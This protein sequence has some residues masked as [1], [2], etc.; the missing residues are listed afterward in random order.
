MSDPLKTVILVIGVALFAGGP[1]R[2]DIPAQ[3]T[4]PE[5]LGVLSVIDQNQI[6]AAQLA[7]QKNVDRTVLDFA[8]TLDVDHNTHLDQTKHL[9]QELKE[10]VTDTAILEKLRTEGRQDRAAL[11]ALDGEDFAQLYVADMIKGDSEA[12]NWMDTQKGQDTQVQDFLQETQ[13]E[14][15][16]HLKDAQKIQESQTAGQL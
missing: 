16:L 3:N 15:Y 1:V 12:L 8:R 6:E 9:S 4:D 7:E 14:F 11:T 13:K 5:T 2:A 10:P